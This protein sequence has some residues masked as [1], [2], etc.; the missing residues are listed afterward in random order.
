MSSAHSALHTLTLSQWA[1]LNGHYAVCHFLIQ[2]GA[3]VNARG[4]MINA[5]PIL[6]AQRRGKVELQ[7]LMLDHGADPMLKDDQGWNLLHMAAKEGHVLLLILCFQQA[8]IDID[9]ADK[10]GC[11]PLMLAAHHGFPAC[12]SVLLR[13]GANAN[14]KDEQGH[15]PL[16]WALTK[17]SIPCIQYLL[18]HGADRFAVDNDGQDLVT[19]ARTFNGTPQWYKA[20]SYAGYDDAGRPIKLALPFDVD[21]QTFLYISFLVSPFFIIGLSAFVASCYPAYIG[22]PASFAV[23]LGSQFALQRA[24]RWAPHGMRS[25]Q[26][27][28]RCLSRLRSR[29]LTLCSPFLRASSWEL[30][31]GQASCGSHGY[32]QVHD[33]SFRLSYS[34]T[35][36]PGTASAFPLANLMFALAFGLTAYF[37]TLSMLS[38]PGYTISSSDKVEV[39]ATVYALIADGVFDA[40]HFCTVCMTRK[41]L[42]SKHCKMCNKC[43]ARHDQY[44]LCQIPLQ[45]VLILSAIVLGSRIALVSTTT[46]TLSATCSACLPVQHCFRGFW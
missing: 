10:Q 7:H 19:A 44:E 40:R 17:R 3:D 14:S 25:L 24:L 37:H 27:T 18:E 43:V 33:H 13:A 4:G 35:T 28:V 29:Q 31:L 21:P 42:R 38:D 12:V 34:L 15:S 2:S 1:A 11:T 20:L 36:A 30:W 32:C 46:C 9:C 5:S 45:H 16:H 8:N 23:S 26:K 41:P 39:K 22:L 6:W